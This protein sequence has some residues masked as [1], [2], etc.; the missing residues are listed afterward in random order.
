MAVTLRASFSVW[1]AN[2]YARLVAARQ[3]QANALIAKYL[4]DL[5]GIEARIKD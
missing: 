2:G 1:F 3:A 5:A 4:K